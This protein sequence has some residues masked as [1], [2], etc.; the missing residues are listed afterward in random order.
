MLRKMLSLCV[1]YFLLGGLH[2]IF[3]FWSNGDKSELL[4]SSMILSRTSD[5]SLNVFELLVILICLLQDLHGVAFVND[6]SLVPLL[7]GFSFSCSPF[8][9]TFWF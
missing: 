1:F 3:K 6:S 7:F 5:L 9:L 4:S 8:Q 2:S